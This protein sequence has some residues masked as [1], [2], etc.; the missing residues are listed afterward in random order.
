MNIG[1]ITIAMLKIECGISYTSI[2]SLHIKGKAGG[3]CCLEA[4]LELPESVTQVRS[5][6]ETTVS[7]PDGTVIFKG[8]STAAGISHRNGYRTVSLTAYDNSME[9]DRTKESR[10][11]QDA[12]IT[13]E[14]LTAHLLQ[15][16]GGSAVIEQNSAV[17]KIL[18][19]KE[20]TDWE[21]LKRVAAGK[22][23]KLYADCRSTNSLIYIGAKGIRRF[24]E[25]IIKEI[26]G[27]NV[28]AEEM[29]NRINAGK[30]TQ[31]YECEEFQCDTEELTAATGDLAGNY[32]ITAHHISTDRG[33][34][35]NTLT[36]ARKDCTA[37]SQEDCSQPDFITGVLEGTVTAVSGNMI[38]V[39]FDTDAGIGGPRWIPYENTLNN[40]FYCMPDEGDR[41]FV[42]YENAGNIICLGSKRKDTSHPDFD[43]PEEKVI[44]NHGKMIKFKMDS[45]E[46]TADRTLHDEESDTRVSIEMNDK[47]GITITSGKEIV[48]KGEDITLTAG[49]T[50]HSTCKEGGS[51]ESAPDTGVLSLYGMEHLILK[52]ADSTI[53]MGADIQIKTPEFKW[54]GYQ[55]GTHELVVDEPPD[56]LGLG[57][58]ILQLGLDICGFIPV[59]GAF[60][61]LANAAISLAR[62]DY[63]G[64][65]L[66]LVAAIPGI[67]DACAAAKSVVK[68]T[69]TVA[70]VVKGAKTATIGL[71]A[72][73]ELSK[74]QKLLRCVELLA[75][76]AIG[77]NSIYQNGD[78]VWYVLTHFPDFDDPE[79]LEKLKGAMQCVSDCLGAAQIAK[80]GLQAP[81]EGS[82]AKSVKST[83]KNAKEN[84]KEM[85]KKI[86][87]RIS[88][89]DPVNVVTGSQSIE[90]ADLFMEDTTS[91]FW[92]LRHYESIYTK[93][94][95]LLGRGWRYGVETCLTGEEKEVI[96]ACMPDMHLEQFRYMEDTK[97]YENLREK[98][99]YCTLKKSGEG[100]LLTDHEERKEYQYTEDGKLRIVRDREGNSVHLQWEK[101]TLQEIRLSCGM[102]YAVEMEGIRLKSLTDSLGRTLTYHY[103]GEFLAA[104]TYADGGTIHY[105]YDANGRLLSYT[106][107][108]GRKIIENTY[109]HR[110]RVTRQRLYGGEEFT[111][112]YDEKEKKNTFV[113]QDTG[114]QVAYYYDSRKLPVK[115]EYEDGTTEEIRYDSHEN[116][117]YEK[118]R[119]GNETYRSY[120]ERSRLVKELLPDGLETYYTYDEND[121]LLKKTDNAGRIHSYQYQ[122]NLLESHTEKWGEQESRT[123]SYCYDSL[124]RMTQ[125]RDFLGNCTQY[126]YQGKGRNPERIIYPDGR[127]K[128]CEYD[129]AGRLL[130]EVTEAGTKTYGYNSSNMRT[131]VIDE[132]GYKEQYRYDL[133]NN[134]TAL[135]GVEETGKAE[136]EI[137]WSRYKYDHLDNIISE[138]D[139][140]GNV[141]KFT[142]NSDGNITS[143][144]T[145][146]LVDKENI[147]PWEGA[148]TKHF[149]DR[150]GRRIKTCNPD[151]SIL[152]ME[153]DPNGNLIK[154]SNPV[155]DSRSAPE[156]NEGSGIDH[157]NNLPC[158]CYTYDAMG[159][160]LEVT[161]PEGVQTEGYEYDLAGNIIRQWSGTAWTETEYTL[162]G[163]PLRK[164]EPV[165]K[166]ED[167][168]ILYRLTEYRYDKCDRLINEKRYV[169]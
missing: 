124:G 164:Y 42:Y 98:D 132:G 162:T 129:L 41:V 116:R 168:E 144:T 61:D 45:L 23:M 141:R 109:D 69:T 57:L 160:I 128:S 93:D 158:T 48:I 89:I 165:L 142:T 118:D 81:K 59:F 37:P 43:K 152:Y 16:Y 55:K 51:E 13:L 106:D 131:F 64:A 70:K 84:M 125:Y 148:T 153:Y 103:E 138:T 18:H 114:R 12:S 5:G 146:M 62:G 88:A 140:L 27:K 157:K 77:G 14:E 73:K 79:Y 147:Y 143:E 21:F 8:K 99:Q 159:R 25:E 86:K 32:I 47:E 28:N 163:Q 134:L 136:G 112:Y 156:D 119:L 75:A 31:S 53:T 150:E 110:G 108:L 155:L 60:F 63:L 80:N 67:G 90:Y 54:E 135:A 7:L 35:T 121:N 107:Q 58:D 105:E 139:P 78:N 71:K 17:G 40:S 82:S 20:E 34:V 122:G 38:Q 6:K 39:A 149:Y 66:S 133:V 19:Q 9:T 10:T 91:D 94:S 102:V 113:N 2:Q 4:V 167:G 123:E 52:V 126:E 101:E 115:T 76:V 85:G 72:F 87:A 74:G 96:T 50:E 166:A 29:R 3:H 151:G 130:A 120:D 95:G 44:T 97:T 137:L 100:Y 92:M 24:S 46:M 26:Q 111:V 49:K 11:F 56:M 145:A 117:I 30:D 22:G 104:V 33:I 83:L 65:G 1:R 127:I 169:D 68:G 36:L 15:S 154:K 161:N